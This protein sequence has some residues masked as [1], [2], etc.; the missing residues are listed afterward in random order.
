[1]S[2]NHLN[3]MRKLNWTRA[4][5]NQ[6]SLLLLLPPEIRNHIWKF[7]LGGKVVRISHG[8]SGKVK[9]SASPVDQIGVPLL[10]VC[11]QIY[12]EAAYIPLS[13]NTFS[14]Y[15]C[16]LAT[17]ALRKLKPHQRK[18][19]VSFRLEAFEGNNGSF[20]MSFYLD[21]IQQLLPVVKHVCVRIYS[22]T[23]DVATHQHEKDQMY[24]TL[25]QYWS[26]SPIDAKVEHTNLDWKTYNHL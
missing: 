24:R 1:M 10:R 2:A 17:K 21:R 15:D 13:L 16:F 20:M 23:A 19:I 14:F 12:A 5:S 3:W 18:Q 6:K 7:V 4:K 25:T 22:S 9:L 26:G 8:F 11:R